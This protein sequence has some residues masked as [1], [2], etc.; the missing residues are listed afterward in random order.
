MWR[1]CEVWIKSIVVLL[2]P[3]SKQ[4]MCTGTPKQISPPERAHNFA[5]APID[6]AHHFDDNV[7][8]TDH[9]I[10]LTCHSCMHLIDDARY[11]L[12]HMHNN[13]HA[14]PRTSGSYSQHSDRSS[15]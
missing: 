5:R 4:T 8:V 3:V 7:C 1:A 11:L 13:A 9:A 6:H 10:V 15:T 12:E 14:H 2:H